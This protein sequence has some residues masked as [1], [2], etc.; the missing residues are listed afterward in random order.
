MSDTLKPEMRPPPPGAGADLLPGPCAICGL[1]NYPLSFGGP[2]IC[3]SCDCG[4]S[5]PYVI[6]R[7]A[8]ELRRLAAEV[9]RL[10][11]TDLP[12]CEFCG[13]GYVGAH[14]CDASAAELATLRAE[15]A[16]IADELARLR[17]MI[18]NEG[19]RP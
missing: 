12:R 5:G 17:T 8:T 2:T 11:K 14:R 6:S 9:E 16:T 4:D 18:F 1:T 7:Q 10:R 19:A 13:I 3:P 15:N